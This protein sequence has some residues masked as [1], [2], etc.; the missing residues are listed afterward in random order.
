M[1]ELVH[2]VNHVFLPILYLMADQ[3]QSNAGTLCR[4][5]L[6]SAQDYYN[7]HGNSDI[8]EP[9][10]KMLHHFEALQPLAFDVVAQ[11]SSELRGGTNVLVFHT[12]ALNA[13]FILWRKGDQII[14][15]YFE[16]AASS[17]HVMTAI[18]KLVCPFP[19][20]IITFPAQYSD[21]VHFRHK[22]AS[23]PTRIG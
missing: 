1:E 9:M 12:R 21:G 18:G 23:F 20:P 19:N 17:D 13:G 11:P 16:A 5:V 3:S 22:L 6:T 15:G 7:V 2:I 4:V 10:I 8:W 14:F